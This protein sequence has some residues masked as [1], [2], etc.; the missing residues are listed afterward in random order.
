M[1]FFKTPKIGQHQKS[2]VKILVE[3]VLLYNTSPLF[4]TIKTKTLKFKL[5]PL[6]CE[7]ELVPVL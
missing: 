6:K 7:F 3:T 2:V 1:N 4:A 5:D